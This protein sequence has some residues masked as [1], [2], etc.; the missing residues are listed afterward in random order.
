MLVN[1]ILQHFL[2]R[3]TSLGLSNPHVNYCN[4]SEILKPLRII[5]VNKS[6]S[7]I[8]RGKWPMYVNTTTV[9]FCFLVRASFGVL[10]GFFRAGL[11]KTIQIFFF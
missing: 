10:V 5:Q 1:V 7:T 11:S 4:V 6:R 3:D 9:T 2:N 8:E